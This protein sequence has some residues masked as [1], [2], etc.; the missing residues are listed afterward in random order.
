MSSGQRDK[1][2]QVMSWEQAGVT[3]RRIREAVFVREQGV[4]AELELDHWDPQC[5]HA[6]V[7]DTAGEA[8]GTGRLL[9]DGHIGRMAVL[10]H[11]RRLGAGTALLEALMAHAQARGVNELMLNAQTHATGFYRRFGFRE[12]GPEFSEA[13]IPHVPMRLVLARSTNDSVTVPVAAPD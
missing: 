5:D 6:L 4:A 8:V 3:A 13:G 2:V 7:Y 11:A 12:C 9:P 1:R 10:P